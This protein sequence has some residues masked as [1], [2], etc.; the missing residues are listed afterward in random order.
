MTPLQLAYVRGNYAVA[1]ELEEWGSDVALT[2][3]H[4]AAAHNDVAAVRK[5]IARKTDVDCLGEMGYVGV[6]RRTPLHWAAISGSSEAVDALL[7]GGAD[8]NFQDVRGRSPL[9]WAAKLNKLEVVRS[10]LRANADPNL[11]DGEFM[12]PLMCA[13]SALDASRELVSEL[14]AA[15][16][17]IGYQLPTTGDTA[18]HVAVREENEASA[19]AVLAELLVS[20]TS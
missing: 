5:F 11:A 1:Q 7:E 9:H 12:T 19:L 13:A 10:L 3:F 6:N 8:P 2:P 16:G 4:L 17:D 14:T 18:L 15:G 20:E